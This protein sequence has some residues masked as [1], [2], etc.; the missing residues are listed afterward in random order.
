MTKGRVHTR[1]LLGSAN[2]PSFLLPRQGDVETVMALH[3]C[4]S[5]CLS[6]TLP[7]VY[8][9]C[10][11]SDS[12]H[13]IRMCQLFP[14]GFGL[15]L[16]LSSPHPCL[17][18]LALCP[19]L[20]RQ[21]F[22]SYALHSSVLSISHR[23]STLEAMPLLLTPTS[24]VAGTP[25]LPASPLLSVVSL[26]CMSLGCRGHPGAQSHLVLHCSGGTSSSRPVSVT[27]CSTTHRCSSLGH[28]YL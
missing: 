20:P 18:A 16:P 24:Y 11:K 6:Q 1:L 19:Q 7:A 3:W 25:C 2:S 4:S 28:H 17:N 27:L 23:L 15:G 26:L 5:S 8:D 13:P 22:L 21:G 10:S 14:P 12:N 9:P